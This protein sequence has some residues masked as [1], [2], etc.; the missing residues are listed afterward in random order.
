[1]K[2]GTASISLTGH[3]FHGFRGM[4]P[5]EIK[6]NK[7]MIHSI[8]FILMVFYAIV[9]FLYI[10]G[11]YVS[12]GSYVE[13]VHLIMGG[14][15]T[16]LFWVFV[17]GAGIVFP[18]IVEVYDFIPHF[19]ERVKAGAHKP[20]LTGAATASVLLGGFMLR[21]VVVYAGQIARVISPA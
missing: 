20:W 6:A 19:N 11:F 21:Y 3:F 15:F 18:L 17:V 14:E 16:L 4:S 1:V 12:P 8:D 2:T 10:F 5:E 7:F 13:A 9:L